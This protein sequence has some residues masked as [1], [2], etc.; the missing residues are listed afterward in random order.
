MKYRA[1]AAWLAALALLLAACTSGQSG[2]GTP[3]APAAGT[4]AATAALAPPAQRL[5]ISVALP[6][7]TTPLI[8]MMEETASKDGAYNRESLDVKFEQIA[9]SAP[10]LQL[11]AAN[12]VDVAGAAAASGIAAYFGGAG[13]LRMIGCVL[14]SNPATD[15]VYA[16]K[17]G[18]DKPADLKGKTVGLTGPPSP[19]DP[20]YA[21]LVDVLKSANLTPEDVQY[22]V[23]GTQAQ[24]PQALVAGRIDVTTIGLEDFN[25]IKRNSTNLQLLKLV[26]TG[27][28]RSAWGNPGS[29]PECWWT[30]EASLKDPAKSQAMQRYLAAV[31]QVNRQ[32]INDRNYFVASFKAIRPDLSAYTDDELTDLWRAQTQGWAVNGNL[33]ANLIQEWLDK[34]Y[35]VSN[36]ANAGKAKVTDLTDAAPMKATLARI[37]AASGH[38]APP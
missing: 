16:T 35:Y 29:G 19:S 5:S 33:N 9:G 6:W 37:G 4:A 27:A 36:P 3:A 8:L 38:D 10:T 23:V 17:K 32:L 22:A 11:L 14:T 24:R 28:F 13:D 30:R 21:A 1:L 12:R 26:P 20:L 34:A 7:T 25:V 31:L 2:T 18:I 15:D